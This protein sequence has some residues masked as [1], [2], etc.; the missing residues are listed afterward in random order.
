MLIAEIRL[1]S[2]ALLI[3]HVRPILPNGIGDDLKL[4]FYIFLSYCLIAMSFLISLTCFSFAGIKA[5]LGKSVCQCCAFSQFAEISTFLFDLSE[6]SD[7]SPSPQVFMPYSFLILL[8]M[9]L[10][11]V[12]MLA[13][14]V[15]SLCVINTQHIGR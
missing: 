11:P 6:D 7:L 9:S 5:K 14:S 2:L 8:L 10:S 13:C 15:L 12:I 1:Q 4:H 3:A